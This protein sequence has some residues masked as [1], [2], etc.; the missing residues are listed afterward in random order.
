[1]KVGARSI[2]H[3]SSPARQSGLP[4]RLC[5]TVTNGEY[6]IMSA[7]EISLFNPGH[8]ARSG[9]VDQRPFGVGLDG[10]RGGRSNVFGRRVNILLCR[11][12]FR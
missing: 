1:M 7:L 9:D 11:G 5:S 6:E 2:P 12:Q 8:E 10:Q 3:R 4:N